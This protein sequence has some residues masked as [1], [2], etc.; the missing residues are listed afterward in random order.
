GSDAILNLPEATK[1]AAFQ[2]CSAQL[3]IPADLQRIELRDGRVSIFAA[4]RKLSDARSLNICA[5][6][7]LL[8]VSAG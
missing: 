7:R 2:Q 1:R 3:G 4:N 6:D 8:A 5:R